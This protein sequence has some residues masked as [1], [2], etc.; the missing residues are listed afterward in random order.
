MSQNS[1]I[2]IVDDEEDLLE[3]IEILVQSSSTLPIQKAKSG[4]QAIKVLEANKNVEFIL[5]DFKMP[6]G[7]GAELFRAAEKMGLNCPFVFCS[8]STPSEILSQ[9]PEA[10]MIVEKPNIIE[11][12]AK[13]LQEHFANSKVK[14]V[15][16]RIG[17]WL[18]L[19][20]APVDIFLKLSEE[21]FVKILPKGEVFSTADATKY[22]GKKILNLYFKADQAQEFVRVFSSQLQL[23]V[24]T[25]SLS[26]A[27][28][29][30][31]TEEA[32]EATSVL[33]QSFG[34][35]KEIANI[36]DKSYR[37]ALAYISRNP[38]LWDLLQ[39]TERSKDRYLVAHGHFLSALSCIIAKKLGWDS[40]FTYAKLTLAALIHDITLPEALERKIL[41]GETLLDREYL[42]HPIAAATLLK[43][44]PGAPPDVDQIL[45][46][47]HEAPDGSGFPS[48]LTAI[49]IS[50]LAAVFIVAQDL[51]K[52]MWEK[53]DA[54]SAIKE[55]VKVRE[56]SY[57]TGHFKK[58]LG[59]VQELSNDTLDK[60]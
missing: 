43:D 56:S 10:K 23:P 18:R 37:H 15:P 4:N 26:T 24:Q 35:G 57:Q 13:I 30:R 32:Y 34:W 25:E 44:I 45:Q 52:F 3:A 20:M 31:Q 2:L 21:N 8:G 54:Q 49:R 14:F 39:G 59:I 36:V 33:Y 60:A 38:R 42:L 58:I 19:G 22:L 41:S 29:L 16:I 27:E 50:P 12:I 53:V 28:L 47:H 55:F 11:P 46:Q 40:E 9:V 6:D 1:Y 48:Q 51:A 7:N 5:S 17:V